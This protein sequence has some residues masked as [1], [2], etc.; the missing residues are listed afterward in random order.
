[1]FNAVFLANLL[2]TAVW[3]RHISH[4][5]VLFMV[6]FSPVCEHLHA[7]PLKAED[8]ALTAFKFCMLIHALGRQVLVAPTIGT[9]DDPE[10]AGIV[11][12]AV[13]FTGGNTFAA[14]GAHNNA[15]R[16]FVL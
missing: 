12:M 16:A 4:F 1:M 11:L 15:R 13:Q 2:G 9:F 7:A 8:E 14:Q 6:P 5:T 10:G 3:A